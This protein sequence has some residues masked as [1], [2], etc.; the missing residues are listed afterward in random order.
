MQSKN[1]AIAAIVVVAVL[2]V[3]AATFAFGDNDN[4]GGDDKDVSTYYFYLDGMDSN[5]GWHSA[6]GDSVKSAFMSAMDEDGVKYSFSGSMVKFDG[7]EGS[8]GMDADG[9]YIGTG[10]SVYEYI[11]TNVVD[12]NASY[13]VA[14]PALEDVVSNIVYISYGDY[15][16]DKTTYE[17]TYSLS[18][19]TTSAKLSESGPFVAD[20]YKP[21]AHGTYYFYLDGMDS[22]GW[23]SAE[24]SDISEAFRTAMD[25]AGVKYNL[26][27]RGWLTFDGY[28]GSTTAT[29]DG[30]YV[31][32]GV[33][34]CHYGSADTANYY[35]GYFASGPVLGSSAAS[36][37]YISFG[38]Y[39]MSGSDYKTTYSVTPDKNTELSVTGPFA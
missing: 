34:I 37:V 14:G 16:S 28:E 3:A 24:G 19:A 39:V 18:P 31:G 4:K 13:F 12:Y 33:S 10:L 15:I 1:M 6:Q 22:K 25:K 7:Y 8:N 2:V 17:T 38:D 27:A 20:D 21:L 36:I 5:N 32:K 11:S 35:A 29:E 26:S 9:N 30:G 23:Y